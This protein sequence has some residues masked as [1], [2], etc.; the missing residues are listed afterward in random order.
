MLHEEFTRYKAIMKEIFVFFSLLVSSIGFSQQV[1]YKNLVGTAWEMVDTSTSLKM[2]FTFINSKTINQKSWDARYQPTMQTNIGYFLDTTSTPT[3][4]NVEWKG[5]VMDCTKCFVSF[6]ENYLII[7]NTYDL[8][9]KSNV[10][11][12]ETGRRRLVFIRKL[13]STSSQ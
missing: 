6:S 8:P 13:A 10:V 9:D 11:K 5:E 7:Q 2:T 4:L 1:T 12:S 3:L